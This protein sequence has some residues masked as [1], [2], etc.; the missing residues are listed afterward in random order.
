MIEQK[1]RREKNANFAQINSAK[2]KET[3]LNK[4]NLANLTSIMTHV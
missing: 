1:I 4:H 3:Q 2:K